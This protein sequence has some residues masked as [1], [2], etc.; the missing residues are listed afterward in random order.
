MAFFVPVR[1]LFFLRKNEKLF[2]VPVVGSTLTDSASDDKNSHKCDDMSERFD[3]ERDVPAVFFQ[4][5]CDDAGDG[6]ANERD[7]RSRN[8]KTRN[9]SHRKRSKKRT[10]T[11]FRQPT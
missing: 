11:Y 7:R 3:D 2:V 9:F 6:N 10:R 4:S 5:W 1:K 8:P